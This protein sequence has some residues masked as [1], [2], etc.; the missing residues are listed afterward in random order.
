MRNEK[1]ETHETKNFKQKRLCQILFYLF[2]ARLC[3]LLQL[4]TQHDGLSQFKLS[5][6][7]KWCVC[8][9]VSVF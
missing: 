9:Y 8:V 6:H 4:Y 2:I 7:M 5:F 3:L 1:S